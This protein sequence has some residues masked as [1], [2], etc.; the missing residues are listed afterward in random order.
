[1]LRERHPWVRW[2][3]GPR[4]GPGANRNSGARHARGEW[5][6]FTDDDCLPEPQWLEAFVGALR[7][8]TELYEGRTTC[9]AGIRRPLDH[10]PVNENG[11][12]L[13]SCNML[14]GRAC[15]EKLG[16]FDEAFPHAHM[17]D[18]DFRERALGAG[19]EF[20]FVRDAV[21]DH[22]PRTFVTGL[23]HGAAQESE[24][25]FWFKSGNTGSFLLR[26]TRRL[27]AGRIKSLLRTRFTPQ[28]LT[29]FVHL[30]PEVAY[31]FVKG[32]GWERKYR[33]LYREGH[34]PFLPDVS[35]RV[36]HR[37]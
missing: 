30:F 36:G 9:R 22:P 7:P 27:A 34:P 37:R 8:G 1:M 18:V 32:P 21:V 33:A 15:Y 14:V 16:G 28:T 13:W 31:L 17:E 3:P 10:S 11:G 23:R 24:F 20:P 12:Y 35:R 19:Y 25:L 26:Q 29:A 6:A 5:L 2:V 4:R